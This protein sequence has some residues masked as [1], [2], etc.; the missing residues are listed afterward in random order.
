MT[1]VLQSFVDEC[2]AEEFVLAIEFLDCCTACEANTNRTE[3]QQSVCIGQCERQLMIA[4]CDEATAQRVC[5]DRGV[6]LTLPNVTLPETRESMIQRTPTVAGMIAVCVLATVVPLACVLRKKRRLKEKRRLLVAA[7]VDSPTLEDGSRLV[8]TA[9]NDA[10]HGSTS[11]DTAT[12]N[13]ASLR[14]CASADSGDVY[15]PPPRYSARF[16]ARETMVGAGAHYYDPFEGSASASGSETSLSSPSG[17]EPARTA[18]WKIDVAEL[19]LGDEIGRGFFGV[20][21][22]GTWRGCDVAC[23]QLHPETMGEKAVREFAAEAKLLQRMRPH[24]NVVLFYG[25]ARVRGTLTLVTQFCE[26]GSLAS[27]LCK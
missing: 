4:G 23:K 26:L 19:S 24:A 8:R 17:V 3:F 11:D 12:S 16:S 27:A 25:V 20:V 7:S 2:V 22:R 6:S 15:S 9:D 21:R 5:Y 13:S 10:E 14:S 18:D 1:I